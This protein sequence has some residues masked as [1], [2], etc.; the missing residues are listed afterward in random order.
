LP[1]PRPHPPYEQEY[2]SGQDQADQEEANILLDGGA[3]PANNGVPNQLLRPFE[4][5]LL[6]V[7]SH[8][9][10]ASF[11]VCAAFAVR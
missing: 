11:V 3:T 6:V 10:D 8:G 9:F 2:C 5:A 1:L 7:S 4:T